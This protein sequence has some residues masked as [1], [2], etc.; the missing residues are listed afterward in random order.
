MKTE[1]EL[2]EELLA[3]ADET[4]ETIY[5]VNGRDGSTVR[6]ERADWAARIAKAEGARQ[7]LLYYNNYRIEP[8]DRVVL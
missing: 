1:T 7:M 6:V 8:Y 4:Q 3:K 5:M 2:I